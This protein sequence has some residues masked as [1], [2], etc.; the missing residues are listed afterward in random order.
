[1]VGMVLAFYRADLY[2]IPETYCTLNTETEVS[3]AF[4][5][6]T[7]EVSKQSLEP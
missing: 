3:S 7:S 1:M 5:L 2:L 4:L 6:L